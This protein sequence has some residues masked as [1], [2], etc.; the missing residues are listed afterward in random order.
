MKAPTW[1]AECTIPYKLQCDSKGV[2]LIPVEKAVTDMQMLMPMQ[3][4]EMF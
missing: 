2:L 1:G 3:F 4:C